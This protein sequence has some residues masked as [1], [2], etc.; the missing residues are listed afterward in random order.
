[1]RGFGGG[2][3]RLLTARAPTS[4]LS[5]VLWWDHLLG[6]PAAARLPDWGGALVDDHY[7]IDAWRVFA[8]A[9]DGEVQLV[10]CTGKTPMPE[11][12]G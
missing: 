12:Q 8:G 10:Y 1:M 7:G 11:G 9:V 2:V 4:P 3:N 6:R 5:P